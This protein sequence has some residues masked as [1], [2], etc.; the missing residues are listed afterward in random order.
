[1]GEIMGFK[2]DIIKLFSGEDT[3]LPQFKAT[4]I[5]D[6]A[7]YIEFVRKISKYSSE[8][9]TVSVKGGGVVIRGESLYI[10]KYC[11]GD[12][13]VCGKIKSLERI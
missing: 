13:A 11:A 1:M 12:L 9:I 10:K 2:D 6:N 7:V 3:A 5:G 8:E 4:L